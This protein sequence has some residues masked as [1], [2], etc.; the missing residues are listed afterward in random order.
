MLLRLIGIG[1][2]PLLLPGCMSATPPLGLPDA[3][4]IGF[5]SR[6]AIAPDCA[7]L[8]QPSHLVDAGVARASM[9]FGCATYTNLAVMLARPEDLVDPLPYAG[10]DATTAAGAVRRYDEG[11]VKQPNATSTTSPLTH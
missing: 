4:V 1:L 8:V 7:T 5:D 9:P 3:S 10:A 11:R 2:L 6:H